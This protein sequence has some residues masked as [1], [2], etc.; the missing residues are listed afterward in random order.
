MYRC[1]AWKGYA[2][3][4][5]CKNC[6]ILYCHCTIPKPKRFIRPYIIKHFIFKTIKKPKPF[7]SESVTF[8]LALKMWNLNCSQM[9][10]VKCTCLSQKV[11]DNDTLDQLFNDLD[12][13][14]DLEID[15]QEFIALIAMVTS[16]CHDFLPAHRWE[17]MPWPAIYCKAKRQWL[18]RT[19]N[20][21][22]GL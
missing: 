9:Y 22:M 1:S 6:C 21:V 10:S 8:F 2:L 13:N 12:Q 16:A 4:E 14:G 11:Q 17:E 20:W 7:Y 19:P 5:H 15:F 3:N 18:H